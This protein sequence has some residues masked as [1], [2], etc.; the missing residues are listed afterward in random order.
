MTTLQAPDSV[1][2]KFAGLSVLLAGVGKVELT[3]LL[4]ENSETSV[5][6]TSRPGL[7][8][9]MFDLECGKPD[10]VS[11]GPYL[12]YSGEVENFDDIQSVD[13]LRRRV[14]TY[15]G[16]N[17]DY[18]RKFA[19][20]AMEYLAGEDLLSWC[21][22]AA[23][24]G[25][26]AEWAAEFRAALFESLTI[27]RLFHE[28]GIILIDFKPDNIIR[29][30]DG[31]IKFVDLGAFF[32]PR[33][34]RETENYVYSAT[35]DYAELVIDTV[36]VQTGLPLTQGSD[37]FSAGVALFEL[38]TGNSRLAIAADCAERMLRNPSIYRFRDSQIE[39]VW[40]AYPHLR[41]LLPSLE[42]QLQEQRILFSEFWHLLKGYL[43]LEVPDWETSGEQKHRELLLETGTAFIADQL[44]EPLKWLADPIARSTTLRS[45]R[46]KSVVDLMELIAD[47]IPEAIREDIE[48]HNVLVQVARDLDPP[49]E[50]LESLNSWEVRLNPQSQHCAIGTRVAASRLRGVASVI[51]L[52]ELCCDENQQH[53]YRVVD[54]REA[55]QRD[56]E[57]L[58]LELCAHDHSAWV[59]A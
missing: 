55:D 42:T 21:Q 9:K 41:E 48:E 6:A 19:Y 47:P 54:D 5:Y 2:G 29:L 31:T 39:R 59:G 51:F 35:P 34:G 49:V 33:H 22:S 53:F 8:V 7:V 18:E 43:A 4:H 14:P 32:T 27:V 50:L 58:T 12:A 57:H 11:Y 30:F 23:E 52:Q 40:R 44:P 25:Y 17:I 13:E 56:G 10:E 26:P 28:H 38:A 3:K 36:N 16:S 24:Q 45:F 37:I 15:Y 46:L 1:G 20:I